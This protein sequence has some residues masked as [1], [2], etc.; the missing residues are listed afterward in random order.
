MATLLLERGADITA[1]DNVSERE[2]ERREEKRRE[3]GGEGRG[4]G[5]MGE[6]EGGG[7]AAMRCVV[8]LIEVMFSLCVN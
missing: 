8:W 6:S 4:E 3:E 7:Y 1:K 2:E 5:G